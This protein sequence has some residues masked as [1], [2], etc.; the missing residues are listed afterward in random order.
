MLEVGYQILAP[1]WLKQN[2]N[3]VKCSVNNRKKTVFRKKEKT[4]ADT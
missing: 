1:N 3:A 4:P 2:K